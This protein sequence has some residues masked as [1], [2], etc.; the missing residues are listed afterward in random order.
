MKLWFEANNSSYQSYHLPKHFNVVE[1][2]VDK[3]VLMPPE[4]P[5][6]YDIGQ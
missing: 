4:P 1:V 5:G 2:S 3:K 6:K